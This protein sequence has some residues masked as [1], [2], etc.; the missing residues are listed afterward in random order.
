MNFKHTCDRTN[1]SRSTH[2]YF[3]RRQFGDLLTVLRNQM[4]F[5]VTKIGAVIQL[6]SRL[7]IFAHLFLKLSWRTL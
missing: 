4:D 5:K 7:R 3:D 1:R 2:C 6:G